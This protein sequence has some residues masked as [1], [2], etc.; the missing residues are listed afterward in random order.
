MNED[1]QL[2]PFLDSR[3]KFFLIC[4][5][6]KSDLCLMTLIL[7]FLCTINKKAVAVRDLLEG[8]HFY[9]VSPLL[10]IDTSVRVEGIA[11][12]GGQ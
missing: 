1:K 8:H 7:L 12:F 3:C 2:I 11:Y 5:Y 4:H 6:A 10:L 9:A